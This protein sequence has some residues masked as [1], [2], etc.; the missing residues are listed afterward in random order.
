[1]QGGFDSGL[2]P[3][4][5][6]TYSI[7]ITDA[8]TREWADE[9]HRRVCLTIIPKAIYFFC[10]FPTHCG[11][12]MVGYVIPMIETKHYQLTQ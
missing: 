4:A 11:L 2:V 10:K 7:N 12:G 5:G 3:N 6:E 8:S 1:M 9:S